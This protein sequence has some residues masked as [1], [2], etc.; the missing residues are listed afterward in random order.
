MYYWCRYSIVLHGL[1]PGFCKILEHVRIGGY[2]LPRF[3]TIV[4][5]RCSVPSFS[6]RMM[7]CSP[8]QH[9]A[10][11]GQCNMPIWFPYVYR[12]LYYTNVEHNCSDPLKPLKLVCISFVYQHISTFDRQNRRSH[13]GPKFGLL[14]TNEWRKNLG[15]R[16]LDVATPLPFA[17]T[18]DL[19]VALWSL[20]ALADAHV[21]ADFENA[22]VTWPT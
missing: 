22:H 1:I 17:Q 6:R 20:E 11:K 14:R 4:H 16:S 12:C 15:Q 7:L 13:G 18:G 19:R 2:R 3:P 10:P 21:L 5:C 9:H 8:S